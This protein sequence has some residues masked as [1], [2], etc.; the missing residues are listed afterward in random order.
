[1][2]VPN[3]PLSQNKYTDQNMNNT[4]F[5]EDYGVNAVEIVG[6]D[7]SAGVLRR[8]QVNTSGYIVSA[9]SSSSTATLANVSGSAS[10][11]TL[12]ASNTSR[13]KLTIFNDSSTNLYIKYG[14]SASSTSFSYKLAPL[15]T[16]EEQ[17]YTGIVTGIWDSATGAARMTELT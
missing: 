3:R 16:L 12:Q 15:D 17:T 11:V 8:I 1:M 13:K 7:V 10:S 9:P 6:E 5:D 4:S 14:S 2:A